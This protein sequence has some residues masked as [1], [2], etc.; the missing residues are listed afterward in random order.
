[1]ITDGI[2][3]KASSGWPN[4]AIFILLLFIPIASAIAFG[5][6]DA[7]AISILSIFSSIIVLL[8]IAESFKSGQVGVSVAAIQ[9]P[10]IGLFI[11]GC[12]QLLPLST[13]DGA[14]LLSVEATRTLTYDPFATRSFIVK[15][16]IL[17]IYFA[18]AL[19]FINSRERFVRVAWAVIIFGAAM[20]IFGILQKLTNPE[21][22]YGLRPTPQAIPFSSFVNQHHFASFML[23]TAG[24]AFGMALGDGLKK[25]KR[26]I[27]WTLIAAMT[28][29]VIFTGSRGGAIG[30]FAVLAT[31]LLMTAVLRKKRNKEEPEGF[32]AGGM[33]AKAA[34]VTAMIVVIVATTLYLGA[35]DNL[36]RGLGVGPEMADTT[37]GR[38]HFWNI[39]LKIFA[40]HPISGAGLDAY[41]TA[42]TKFDTDNGTFRLEYAHNEY[43]QMLADGG[44]VAFLLVIGFI[45]LLIRAG[46]K[47]FAQNLDKMTSSIAIGAFA[48]CIGVAVHSMFDFPLRTTSNAFFFLLLTTLVVNGSSFV[49]TRS[50]RSA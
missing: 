6:V 47:L 46:K 26:L 33:L 35:G 1:M 2:Q 24:V 36:F 7:P 21:A 39:A 5:A 10:L 37:N 19:V 17:I 13:P 31:S 32:L 22:I 11:L 18:A 50:G 28:L 42:F 40:E 9:I 4:I 27:V 49:R 44:I 48:G 30:Y 34:V 16:V 8:W 3:N 15:A 45:V 14:S 41:G 38:L 43:L 23:M 20:S 12:I 29:G 25:D